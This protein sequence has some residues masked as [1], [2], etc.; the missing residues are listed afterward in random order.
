M[1]ER[2][3]WQLEGESTSGAK[4]GTERPIGTPGRGGQRMTTMWEGRPI[5]WDELDVE[6]EEEEESKM[7]SPTLY[8][9]LALRL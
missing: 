4:L 8:L 1:T 7:N 9:S 3:L 5:F 2:T 6:N